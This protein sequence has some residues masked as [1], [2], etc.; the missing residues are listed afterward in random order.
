M[1]FPTPS[2]LLW[3]TGFAPRGRWLVPLLKE[4]VR[5]EWPSAIRLAQVQLGDDAF[6]REHLEEALQEAQE[7][8]LDR[9]NPD[10]DEVRRELMR[11]YRNGIRRT[12][13]K[14]DRI[15]LYGSSSDLDTLPDIKRPFGEQVE[16]EADIKTLLR[17]TPEEIQK[18]LLMRYGLCLDWEDIAK[19]LFFSKDGI[20]MKCKRALDRLAE[21]SG[22]KRQISPN[23]AKT[24]AKRRSEG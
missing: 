10:L 1:A 2:D 9:E 18:A 13:R 5:K 4:A 17:D 16:A 19:E 21:R 6:A 11:C 7:V 15:S 24:S 3:V 22:F 14:N 12:R 20:R 23:E 8:L